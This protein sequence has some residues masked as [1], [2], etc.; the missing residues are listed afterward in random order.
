VIAIN[1]AATWLKKFKLPE[2]KVRF[3]IRRV[4][5]KLNLD[6][7]M[8]ETICKQSATGAALATFSPGGCQTALA[9]ALRHRIG[10]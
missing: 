4:Y 10:Q 5:Q 8:N 2:I 6:Q 9:R 7:P 1:V 3:S